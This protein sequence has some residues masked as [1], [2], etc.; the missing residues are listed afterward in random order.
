MQ[1]DPDCPVCGGHAWKLAERRTFRAADGPRRSPYVALR[2]RVLFELW[3]PQAQEVELSLQYC[4]DCGLLL[5]APRPTRAE[6]D[7]K[8][9]FLETSTP[10]PVRPNLAR[11]KYLFA[12][13]A[14]HLPNRP[15]SVLDLGGGTGSLLTEFVRHGHRCYTVDYVAMTIPGVE[16]L[17]SV[18][19][20]LPADRRFDVVICSHVL[21]HVAEPL[22]LLSRLVERL[23]PAGLGYVEVPLELLG[24]LP[25]LK[26]PVTHINFFTP[27][28]AE[29]LCA[30]AGLE[31]LRGEITP[32]LETLLSYD[33]SF[34]VLARRSGARVAIEPA[35][36]LAMQTE[37]AVRPS[38]AAGARRLAQIGGSVLRPPAQW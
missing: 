17:A 31:L 33:T 18:L 28:S 25:P 27:G 14:P 37:R 13:I 5:Y 15:V 7:A 36:A 9:R 29:L 1:S 10:T 20:E 26:E 19:D 3:F 11:A 2:Y 16:R 24:G 30:R 32:L 22:E 12:R 21:E 8:Y 35:A 4:G 23:E 34:H 6:L 38:L